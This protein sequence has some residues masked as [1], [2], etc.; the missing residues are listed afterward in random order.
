[1]QDP[2]GSLLTRRR[3]LRGALALSATTALAS[4]CSSS[5]SSNDRSSTTRGATAGPSGER[6]RGGT[7]RFAPQDANSSDSMNPH[8][9]VGSSGSITAALFSTLVAEGHTFGQ[10]MRLAE[11]FEPEG[12]DQGVWT[13]RLLDGVE[14]HHGKTLDAD[15]LIFSIQ[16]ILDPKDPGFISGLMAC[17]D[18]N[19]I[20]KMDKRT[21]RLNLKTPNSQLREV[22]QEFPA[23]VI[24][25][26][27]DPQN[28]MGTG[29]FK[30]V[31]YQPG[32]RFV[33]ERFD[34]YFRDNMPYLDRI[35]LVSFAD[36]GTAR[37]N[38]LVSGQID[39]LNNLAPSL[40]SQAEKNKDLSVLI[41]ETGAFE[42]IAMRSG[43]G[44]QFEDP[45]V[46]LAMKLIANRQLMV[47][48]AYSGYGAVGN[49]LGCWSDWD[50]GTDPDL[51]AREQDIDKAKS[52]LKA[53]GKEGMKIQLRVGEVVPGQIAAA[54]AFAQEAKKAG[55]SVTLDK[56]T[57][58]AQFYGSE[59]YVTSQ[60]KNDYLFTQTMY[61]NGAYCWTKDTYFN[62]TSYYNPE[63]EQLF[64]QALASPQEEFERLMQE[65]SRII[66]DDGPWLVWG[67]R[68]IIDAHSSKFTGAVQDATGIGL[69]GLRWDEISL[70]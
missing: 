53:A 38:A 26:D 61:T 34:N 21:V 4:A 45:N 63:F 35:E 55:L 39:G 5:P 64:N 68:N 8:S 49:D 60:M 32:Q 65:A 16:H 7:F 31:S 57:D 67:R 20:K 24:P 14:F 9:A 27:F 47:D 54:E 51:A 70:A 52:L 17:V 37:F 59:D 66:Y 50:K 18:P 29:P 19:N 69:N 28:P 56:V 15:D 25:V 13:I 43:K 6:K 2:F 10:E 41:S 30:Y 12:N 40:V 44:D 11:I 1:M 62:N 23:A 42:P 58:L 48:S 36:S 3:L 33:A 46:R 22:F